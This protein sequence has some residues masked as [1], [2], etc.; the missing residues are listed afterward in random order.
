MIKTLYQR[1]LTSNLLKITFNHQTAKATILY[2]ETD[3]IYYN[4][5]T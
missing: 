2:S 1:C 4:L 3:N 5:A